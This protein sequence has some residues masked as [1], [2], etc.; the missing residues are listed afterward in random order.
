MKLILE[1]SL[2]SLLQTH[3]CFI[4]LFKKKKKTTLLSIYVNGYSTKL[5]NNG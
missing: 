2:R 3:P 1:S 4:H 5:T